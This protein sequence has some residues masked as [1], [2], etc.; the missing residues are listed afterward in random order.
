[1]QQHAPA[2]EYVIVEGRGRAELLAQLNDA[3]RSGWEA[4]GTFS[5]TAGFGNTTAVLLKR[6]IAR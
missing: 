5:A 6:P 2:W 3:G 1:M 4:V